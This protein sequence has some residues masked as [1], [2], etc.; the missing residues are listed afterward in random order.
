MGQYEQAHPGTC[1][2]QQTNVL[3]NLDR[4]VRVS[5]TWTGPAILA[6]WGSLD[7]SLVGPQIVL[8]GGAVAVKAT[9]LCGR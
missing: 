2:T 4:R 7:G 3:V 6:V 1:R 5:I 9:P 8:N